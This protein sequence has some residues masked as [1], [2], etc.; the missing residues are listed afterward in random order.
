MLSLYYFVLYGEFIPNFE[1]FKVRISWKIRTRIP[2]HGKNRCYKNRYKRIS[3]ID[4]G[5]FHVST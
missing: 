1:S 2:I 4:S 3:C 5:M